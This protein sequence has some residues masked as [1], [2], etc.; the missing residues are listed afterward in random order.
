[1]L[2]TQSD[3]TVIAPKSNIKNASE[4]SIIAAPLSGPLI[5]ATMLHNEG[6]LVRFYDETIKAPDY[7]K[8]DSDYILISS[9]SCTVNRA[10][11]IADYF[12][13]KGKTV[14][15]GGLHVSCKPNEA[16]QHCD[17]VV[18]G[19]AE[20]VIIDLIKG[21]YD[22]CIIT[23]TNVMDL[24]SIPMPDYNLIGGLSSNPKVVSVSSSR[25]C[26]FNCRFCSLHKVFGRKFRTISTDRIIRYLQN[27]KTLKILR[28]DEPNF[29]TNK[30]RAIDILTQMKEKSVQP[31]YVLMSVSIDVAQNDQFLKLCSDVSQFQ[32]LIGLESV[33]QKVLDSYNKKQTPEIIRKGIKKLHD[34][35]IKI[36]GSFIYGSDF[37][38]KNVFS[39]TVDFCHDANVDFPQFVPLTPYVGTDIRE[40]FERDNRIITNNWDYY[41]GE[42]VVI[43]PKNMTP[44]ELQEGVVNSYE[45]F[46]SNKK[47]FQHLKTGEVF[48]GIG[49]LYVKSLIKKTVR[50]NRD[51]FDYLISLEDNKEIISN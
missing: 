48:Y 38:D 40:D 49:T 37:D 10:Y 25:G 12:K 22:D 18:I 27:F 45:D 50:E 35:G 7:E 32:F 9:M 15:M 8:I 47:A 51:Y 17:K 2:E 5:L 43:Y 13:S 3:I 23:G 19:E 36:Q 46:Y 4:I 29:S 1:M 34:Y 24:D 42:H 41:D 11:E 30:E 31:K 16:L 20:H 21:K 14:F 44:Y 33:S 39:D 28:F 6:H 26:P